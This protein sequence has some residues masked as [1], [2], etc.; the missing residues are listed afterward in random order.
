MATAPFDQMAKDQRRMSAE[1]KTVNQPELAARSSPVVTTTGRPQGQRDRASAIA[2]RP[3][4]RSRSLTGRASETP[5]VAGGPAFDPA[6]QAP[7]TFPV[8]PAGPAPSVFAQGQADPS[9]G[10]LP[11]EAIL[12][13][14]TTPIPTQDPGTPPAVLDAIYGGVPPAQPGGGFNVSSNGILE[15]APPVQTQDS[16]DQM[17][18]DLLG[19]LLN[20][21]TT[22]AEA[23]ARQRTDDQ[24]SQAQAD[25]QAQLG[26]TGFIGAGVGA[27][28]NAD[29]GRAG[30]RAFNEDL[31][32]I[33]GDARDAGLQ[34]AGLA[35]GSRELG[36]SERALEESIAAIHAIL[37]SGDTSE[38]GD[39]PTGIDVVDDAIGAGQDF[40]SNPA[41][42]N[43][44]NDATGGRAESAG[45]FLGDFLGSSG[46]TPFN[47]V[48]ISS[49]DDV[50]A[51]VV[52]GDGEKFPEPGLTIRG[53]DGRYYYVAR[54]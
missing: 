13:D 27:G 45:Q 34:A 2:A 24:V 9:G 44:V 18:L 22:E 11:I 40:I 26:G 42:G 15:Q 43:A 39:G 17:F 37:A 31:L 30:E 54:N 7:P 50:P 8:P 10:G 46:Q 32:G 47:P 14:L 48:R 38:G 12:N 41:A 16:I 21:D 35:L 52:L 20:P 6:G 19:D 53:S 23:L 1:Q 29:I 28:L 3:V 4:F 51:G 36:I 5:T 33:R 49:A 25:A